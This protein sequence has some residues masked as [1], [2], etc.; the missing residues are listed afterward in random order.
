MKFK[1]PRLIFVWSDQRRDKPKAICPFN[2]FKDGGIIKYVEYEQIKMIKL[3]IR[4][5]TC[6]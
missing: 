3:Q 4:T 6:S 1:N 2:F 5:R